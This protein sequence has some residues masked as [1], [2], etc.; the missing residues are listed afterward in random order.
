[1]FCSN[2]YVD[3]TLTLEEIKEKINEYIGKGV[4]EIIL[5]G[6]EPT[7][8]PKLPEVIKYV[9]K[10][11]AKPRII[12]NGQKLSE[13]NY[14]QEL[15]DSGLEQFMVSIYSHERKVQEK[16][17]QTKGSYDKAIKALE[18]LS[19]KIQVLNINIT[20]NSLNINKLQE[21]TQFLVQ[22][23]PKIKHFVFNNIDPEPDRAK[24]NPWT[25][26]L[27]V[28]IELPLYK[29]TNFLSQNNRTFRIERVPLCY[30]QG[31]EYNS[32]ETR[33]IVKDQTYRCYFL[34]KEG[35]RMY[36]KNEHYYD[37]PSDCKI[38][39]LNEICAGINK[40]YNAMYGTYEIYPV[41]IKKEKIISRILQN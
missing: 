39:H 5:S 11:G 37:K 14:L 32:T 4:N 3:D 26:P 30:M 24:K 28:D 36:E 13:M 15:L 38:C 1:V 16:L 17:T 12:T 31:F 35:R 40:A 18:N 22:R 23:F 33:R 7:L 8:H 29:T 19:Q 27:L 2:Y 21:T 10:K 41:F 25:I 6:G 9:I 34:D 20:I